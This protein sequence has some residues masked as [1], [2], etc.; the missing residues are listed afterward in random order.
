MPIAKEAIM[1]GD[2][3]YSDADLQGDC[4]FSFEG[5]VTLSLPD[6]TSQAVPVC[7]VGQVNFDGKGKSPHAVRTF[8]F[9]GIVILEQVA[10]GEYQVNPD[11]T[12]TAKFRVTTEKVT[13]SL[14]PGVELPPVALETFSFVFSGPGNEEFQFIATG[15]LNPETEQPLAAVAARGVLRKQH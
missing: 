8:S 1:N 5:T 15:Y 12:G 4:G 6:G 10:E 11:G 14:P 7:A 2:K 13:G 9:G 3:R